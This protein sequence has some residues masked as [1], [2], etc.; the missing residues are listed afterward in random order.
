MVRPDSET[1]FMQ[2]SI[3]G[4]LAFLEVY[5]R[6]K[7]SLLIT[8]QQ[9]RTGKGSFS[10]IRIVLITSIGLH[11]AAANGHREFLTLLCN[12]EEKLIE[13]KDVNGATPLFLAIRYNEVECL[14]ILISYDCNIF[15]RM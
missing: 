3:L 1:Y 2:A 11:H 8:D 12:F 9:S 14:K 10:Y 7:G 6:C 5:I 4:N 15:H 13:A